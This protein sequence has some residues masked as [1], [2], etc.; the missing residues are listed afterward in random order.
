VFLFENYCK[1]GEIIKAAV[2]VHVIEQKWR[3][4]GGV[5]AAAYENNYNNNSNEM[6]GQSPEE[7]Y[8]IR[9]VVGNFPWEGG[10]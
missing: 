4:R 8:P 5:S 10:A 6:S 2:D 3:G 9:G 1:K 7:Y